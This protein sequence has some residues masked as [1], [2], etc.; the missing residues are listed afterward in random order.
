M[1]YNAIGVAN[2]DGSVTL[3]AN[4]SGSGGGSSSNINA[5]YEE[6]TALAAHSTGTY[7]YLNNLVYLVTSNI[8]IGDTITPGTNVSLVTGKGSDTE[9]YVKDLPGEG[10]GGGGS[11]TAEDVSYDN[12]DS[13]LTADNV[14]DAIDEVANSIKWPPTMTSFIPTFTDD[15]V[16]LF[17]SATE[18]CEIRMIMRIASGAVFRFRLNNDSIS[19]FGSVALCS[20]SGNFNAIS[21]H[22]DELV[23]LGFEH[24]VPT[25]S[26]YT[27]QGSSG[28]FKFKLKKGDNL[29][30][31]PTNK[32]NSELY[33][34]YVLS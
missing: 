22:L 21:D 15:Q 3:Y 4:S 29:Y 34:A 1:S 10:G 11:S 26:V 17:Y 8:A 9:V 7:I 23:V 18:D 33:A 30:V 12:T 2:G 5:V 19:D 25:L 14:Q 31:K 28:E 6:T 20:P 32:G 16:T 24:I 13:G 27:N